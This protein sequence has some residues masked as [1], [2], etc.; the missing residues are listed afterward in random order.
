MKFAP[1]RRGKEN[2]MAESDEK[3]PK[4]RLE[5]RLLTRLAHGGRDDALCGPFVNPPVVHASTVLFD[6]V[7][8]MR[9]G[10]QR[11]SYGRRGTPTTEAL[12]MA[13]SELEGAAGTVLCPSGLGA[14]STALLALLSS[15][16]HLLMADNV[17]DPSRHVATT[18][19]ARLG[20]ETTFFDPRIGGGIA[21]LIRPNTRVVYVESPGSLT[22]EIADIPAIAA[23]AH[24]AGALVVTDNTWATPYY[25]PT[26][27][28]GADV[29]LLAA[30]KYIGGHSD[31]MLGTISATEAVFG[32]IHDAHGALGLCVGP[33]DIYLGL[34]GLRTL[35]VRLAHHQRSGLAVARH[36]EGR[37]EVARVLHPALSGHPDHALWKRDMSGASGLFGVVLDGWS[38]EKT[39]A[40]L[41]ALELFSLGYSWGGFESL[42][43]PT[44][45]HRT[46]T[47]WAAEGPLIR[48]HV[49]LE[50]TEDLVADLDAAFARV[51]N[52][53]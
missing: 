31:I 39:S 16:D 41:E 34:R 15:G 40:F 42:A 48:L 18:V 44:H 53:A 46:A 43:I 28:L 49:G 10:G 5:T 6:S 47:T 7:D 23:A 52:L 26:L 20:V 50:D 37:A 22:F 51:G 30:T 45:M 38:R 36:L 8:A 1:A 3:R 21:A 14:I 17:Y 25:C 13:M 12:E 19:L 35:G 2:A 11:Y 29:T 33:D 27:A 4:V 24:A 32:R 9:P